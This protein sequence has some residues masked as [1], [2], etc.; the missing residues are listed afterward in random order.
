MTFPA[1]N[2]VSNRYSF[3]GPLN[4]EPCSRPRLQC[5][6]P[7][8]PSS[9]TLP[10]RE[11]DLV[12]LITALGDGAGACLVGPAGVGKSRLA[13]AAASR[14]AEDGFHVVSV[15]AT[16]SASEL[17]L[18]PFLGF[19]GST[20]AGGDGDALTRLFAE[21]H[22][23]LLR[24]AAGRKILFSADDIDLLDDASLVFLHQS[25][26][27][28]EASLLATLRAGR[29]GPSEVADLLQRGDVRRL[30]VQPFTRSD[31]DRVA[32]AI[33]GTALDGPT[34]DRLWHLCAGNALFLHEVLTTAVARGALTDGPTGAKLRELPVDAPN[35]V[36]F[37]KS[38]LTQLGPELREALT[39]LAFAEPCGPGELASTADDEV[40][41]ALE[42]AELIRADADGR[43]L[44]LRLSHPLY[45]EVVRA[46]TGPLQRRA[47]LARLARDLEATGARRRADVVKLARLAVDG[48][49]DIAP[50][51]FVRAASLS[52]HAGDLVLSER[53]GRRAFERTRSFAA[54]WDV[55]NCLA[56]IGDGPAAREHL[57][58]W[59]ATATGPSSRLAVGMAEAQLAYWLEGDEDAAMAAYERAFEA[60]PVDE[61]DPPVPTVTR[62]ELLADRALIEA[63]SGR[64]DAALELAEPLLGDP[65]GQ[66]VI[67]AAF[68]VS[69]ALRAKAR[70]A[71]ALDV[72]DRAR[73]AYRSIGQEAI[74]LSARLLRRERA[75]A[76]VFLGRLDDARQEAD[77]IG[78]DTSDE[79]YQALALS[80]AATI[81]AIAGRSVTATAAVERAASLTGG[82]NRFAVAARWKLAVLTRVRATGG[83]LDGAE[84]AL[85]RFDRDHHPARTMDLSAEL[86]RARIL[87]QSGF[88]EQ[89]RQVL[90]HE[91]ARL[92]DRGAVSDELIALH[93]LVRHD[94][95]EEVVDRMEE[96][97]AAT[98]GPL[99]AL[100]AREA[101]AVTDSDPAALGQVAEE[102]A[103]IGFDHHAS[104]AALRASEAA[105]RRHQPRV[106]TRW[107][108]R[109]NDLRARC[110]GTPAVTEMPRALVS[111]TR[112]ER[113][114]A[115]LAARG[116]ASKQIGARLF[117]S[118]RTVDNHLAKVYV[119][120][121]VRT[122]TELAE[123]L[124]RSALA[125]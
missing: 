76:L 32:D 107:L 75:I 65:A 104:E 48:G 54:G 33:V 3:A 121:G 25:V 89:A 7:V 26:V 14:A 50:D 58:A 49:V 95:A 124:G 36:E 99:Y 2:S 110:E 113:E 59:R 29:L 40:L 90:R 116:L 97:A 15:R 53:I 8:M 37:V 98:E 55:F 61:V 77:R 85:A 118:A 81:D 27:R 6:V 88:P 94:R 30:E 62:A 82:V 96:L 71:A 108:N 63:M 92:R 20:D 79:S 18:A 39:H 84:E 115:L 120:L 69:H 9:W 21:I 56:G 17:P 64:P 1:A 24:R 123:V 22:E 86:G 74:S 119:K 112:R 83:D 114:I 73:Q 102:L 28:G 60:V 16:R 87:R 70:P 78:R 103:A 12:A 38:R 106:A 46:E 45:G 11:R 117:I 68:A 111:I 23:Q 47:I 51:L 42:A 122:R 66:V 44:R 19:V 109:A 91:I 34:R 105:E 80:A 4:R 10:G 100:M 52:Y 125:V 93:E 67:R 5:G 35:L 72:L 41:A 43:R 31:A 101:R 57:V 13:E